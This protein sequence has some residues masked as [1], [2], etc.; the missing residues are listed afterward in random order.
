M[1]TSKAPPIQFRL[2]HILWAMLITGIVSALAAPL[3]RHYLEAAPDALLV[4]VGAFFAGGLLSLCVAVSERGRLSREAGMLLLAAGPSGLPRRA[5]V[6][7]W[8]EWSTSAVM[9]WMVGVLLVTIWCGFLWSLFGLPYGIPLYAFLSAGVGYVTMRIGLQTYRRRGPRACEI[10]A[11]G[12]LVGGERLIPWAHIVLYSF[13]ADRT[14]LLLHLRGRYIDA[15]PVDPRLTGEISD[16]LDD[17]RAH[18]ATWRSMEHTSEPLAD[19][20]SFA[21]RLRRI[22][23]LSLRQ[24][25]TLAVAAAVT[26]ALW[27]P[28]L[29]PMIA[30]NLGMIP[31]FAGLSVGSAVMVA[32]ILKRRRAALA[33]DLGPLVLAIGPARR[34]ERDVDAADWSSGFLPAS[35][36]VFQRV[37]LVYLVIR[38]VDIKRT[39]LTLSE[40]LVAAPLLGGLA[41]WAGIAGFRDRRQSLELRRNGVLA[42]ASESFAWREI[43]RAEIDSR[44]GQLVLY[45]ATRMRRQFPIDPALA[46]QAAMVIHELSRG[47]SVAI[48]GATIGSR[49]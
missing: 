9:R 37:W 21:S 30:D 36:K 7:R 13:S 10:R 16:W 35:L 17:R 2:V 45:L 28:I 46:N 1:P 18:G 22:A 8:V 20:A 25:L 11:A 14:R 39:P 48:D 4:V 24:W 15:V 42:S 23:R 5:R 41:G 6:G 29:F 34:M 38:L 44:E 47:L 43:R 3:V 33:G 19:G 26:V 27:R 40:T 31:W 32:R 12:L 49:H